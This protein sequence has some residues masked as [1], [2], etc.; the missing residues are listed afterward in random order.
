MDMRLRAKYWKIGISQLDNTVQTITGDI[1]VDVVTD[2][3]KLEI[4][5]TELN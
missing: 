3:H 5:E 4:Q 1:E 2:D